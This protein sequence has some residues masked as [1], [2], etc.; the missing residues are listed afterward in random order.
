MNLL[1]MIPIIGTT[2]K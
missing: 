2:S 1:M